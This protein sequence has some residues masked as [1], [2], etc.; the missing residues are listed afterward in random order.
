[1]VAYSFQ[2]QFVEPIWS[3][4][5]TQTIRSNGK[6]RHAML[7]DKLQLYTGMRTK[8]CRLFARAVCDG[9]APIRID[10]SVLYPGDVVRIGDGARIL[11]GDLDPFAQSDGFDDWQAMRAFWSKHHPNVLQFHGVIIYWRDME[12]VR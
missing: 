7:G 5:K 8:S 4:R 11:Q 9:S 1:M 3:G 12:P 10:F 6:R 2:P